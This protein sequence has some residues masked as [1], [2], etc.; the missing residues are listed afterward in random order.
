MH[1]ILYIFSSTGSLNLESRENGRWM[2]GGGAGLGTGWHVMCDRG[3][4]DAGP[5]KDPRAK[6]RGPTM[7]VGPRR[8]IAARRCYVVVS[9]K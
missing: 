8:T 4:G 7:M 3:Q 5:R 1:I 6:P 2:E 9:L